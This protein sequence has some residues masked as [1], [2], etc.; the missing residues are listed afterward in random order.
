MGHFSF[1]II[2]IHLSSIKEDCVKLYFLYTKLD[3]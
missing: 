1:L 3:F 2:L